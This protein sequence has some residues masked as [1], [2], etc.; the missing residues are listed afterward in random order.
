M[1]LIRDVRRVRG[2]T[3]LSLDKTE[4][5][6]GVEGAG[7]CTKMCRECLGKMTLKGRDVWNSRKSE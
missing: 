2:V 1:C 4:V 7:E 6:R 3:V 5:S